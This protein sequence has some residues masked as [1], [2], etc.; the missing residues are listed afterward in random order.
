[1]RTV[2]LI[3]ANEDQRKNF[4]AFVCVLTC[5]LVI[6]LAA[7]AAPVVTPGSD[8]P[9]TSIVSSTTAIPNA[10]TASISLG[11]G[12][13]NLIISSDAGASVVQISLNGTAAGATNFK[14]QAG[15]LIR[16]DNLPLVS[17]LSILGPSTPTG[18]VNV[19]AW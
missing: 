18:N 14:L 4:W 10:T 3:Y 17:S 11:A 8:N 5:C 6:G 12:S 13:R 19:L 16:M 9:Y 15:Q 7:L 1:M 2:K